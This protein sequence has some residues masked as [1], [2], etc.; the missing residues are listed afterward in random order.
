MASSA[1]EIRATIEASFTA[2]LKRQNV[3]PGQE[4]QPPWSSYILPDTLWYV[5]PDSFI[6]EHPFFK[7]VKTIAEHEE[8]VAQEA[9]VI[10]ESRHKI[11]HSVYDSSARRASAIVEHWT[12][13]FGKEPSAIEVCWYV[14]FTENG[15]MISRV[16]Q[17]IDTA[18]GAKMVKGLAEGGY[19]MDKADTKK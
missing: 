11:L 4:K 5:K 14:D 8:H 6:A 13:L 9:G 1:D 16:T 3:S 10:E 19:D 7:G 17:F 12:K 15:K 2:F 18:L